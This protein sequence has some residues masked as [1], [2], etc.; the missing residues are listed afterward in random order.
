MGS[1]IS[2]H[3]EDCGAEES[4]FT[5]GGMMFYNEPAVVEA[6]KSG[7]FGN[8]MKAL[9]GNGVP[10]GWTVFRENAFYLCPN[11]GGVISGGTLKIDD[12]GS[13]WLVYHTE[14]DACESC[15]EE[16]VFWDDKVPLSDS[17]LIKRCEEY[18]ENGCPKCNGKH[19]S[20]SM[21][22]WD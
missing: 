3:C 14:P 4:F 18:S 21:G 19:V 15:G 6:S 2:W 20:L 22:N 17:E 8:A 7:D 11:C 10:E 9:L 13:G 12:G 16:L 5:G 1:M